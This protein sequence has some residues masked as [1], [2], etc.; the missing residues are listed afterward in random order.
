[1]SS[2]SKIYNKSPTFIE[3]QDLGKQFLQKT[4]VIKTVCEC[5]V[6]FALFYCGLIFFFDV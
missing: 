4:S 1:M 3:L 6:G 5:L 2:I